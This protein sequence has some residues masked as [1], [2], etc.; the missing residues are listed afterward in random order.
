[1][2]IKV[3]IIL[4]FFVGMFAMLKFEQVY[5]IKYG[6]KD[7]KGDDHFMSIKELSNDSSLYCFDT[8]HPEQAEQSGIPIACAGRKMYIDPSTVHSLIVGTTRS[9]KGQTFVLPMIRY[10]ALSKA[11]HSFVANDP[12]GELAENLYDTLIAQGYTVRI[13]NLRDTNFSSLFDPLQI[14]KEEYVKARKSKKTDYDLSKT[15]KLVKSLALMFTENPRSDPIWPDS[16]RD[17][18]I[19]MILLL[20]ERG[21]EGGELEKVTMYSVYNFFVEFGTKDIVVVENGAKKIANLLDIIFQKLP[22]GNPAKSAY[23]TSNFAKGDMRSSIFSTLSSNI[24]IFGT[25]MGIAK[26]TSGNQIDFAELINPEKPCAIF[27][28]VPD[29][30]VSRHIISSLFVNQCYNDLVERSSKFPMQKLPQRVHFILDEFGNMPRIT[31]MDTKITVGAGRNLLFNLFVQDLNQL[32]TKYDNASKTIRS[33]CGNLIY[34][35]SLDK[36]TNDYISA[37]IGNET[38][39]YETYSGALSEWLKN[40]NI[41]VEQRPLMT[42]TQLSRMK[43]GETVIKRQRSQPIK[44]KFKPFYKLKIPVTPIVE[45]PIEL[46]KRELAD[47]IYPYIDFWYFIGKRISENGTIENIPYEDMAIHKIETS[48]LLNIELSHQDEREKAEEQSS[49]DE[50][51]KEKAEAEELAERKREQEKTERL[52]KQREQEIQHKVSIDEV[53][54][55]FKNFN[56]EDVSVPDVNTDEDVD[57]NIIDKIFYSL[58]M[59][60]AYTHIT[61]KIPQFEEF[62]I[63]REFSDCLLMIDKARKIRKI[64]KEDEELVRQAILDFIEKN[65]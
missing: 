63:N 61:F 58:E 56:D 35:N 50:T 42:G 34:I 4:S 6:N 48:N 62:I 16:A 13:L 22:I 30:D 3:M 65:K 40:R 5:K 7:L 15:S 51:V 2:D 60:K 59:T 32:D 26:L 27:M 44:T 41:N 55:S 47:K 37:V 52:I 19:A 18:L 39:Q 36:D 33:N 28:V 23:S 38:I 17:L 24:N 45:I 43:F 9:G 54:E 1:M 29:E 8:S 57:G 11:K 49:E 46:Q 21:Y 10:M 53:E 25:D 31:S 14:I 64:T 12:K 20:L